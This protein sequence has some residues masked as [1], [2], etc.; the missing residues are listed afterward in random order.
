MAG[1][2]KS[3][4]L[5]SRDGIVEW[6]TKQLARRLGLNAG[7]ID[8]GERFNRY[9]LESATATAMI[10]ELSEALGRKLM[11]T[12]VWDY[13]TIEKLSEFLSSAGPAATPAE[14]DPSQPASAA[15]STRHAQ[16]CGGSS[17]SSP[18]NQASRSESPRATR[19]ATS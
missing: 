5:E 7:D 4:N 13:P 6:L 17:G 11:P 16:K 19:Q 15:P 8:V 3:A 2:Q 9:G 14:P 1:Q 10:T 18:K 12:L